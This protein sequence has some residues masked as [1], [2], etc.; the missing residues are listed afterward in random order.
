MQFVADEGDECVSHGRGSACL[1][2]DFD[3]DLD[4]NH[5]AEL[6]GRDRAAEGNENE[7]GGV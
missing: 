6:R 5:G 2:E 7:Q 4:A 3:G 1:D